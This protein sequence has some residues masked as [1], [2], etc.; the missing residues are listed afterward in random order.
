MVIYLSLKKDSFCFY[1]LYIA[2]K[3]GGS[4]DV[5]VSTFIFWLEKKILFYTKERPD[6]IEFVLVWVVYLTTECIHATS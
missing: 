4:Y 3:S 5:T 1:L 2:R 6:A